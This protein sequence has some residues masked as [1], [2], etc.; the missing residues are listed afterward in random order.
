MTQIKTNQSKQQKVSLRRLDDFVKPEELLFIVYVLGKELESFCF[1]T[2]QSIRRIHGLRFEVKGEQLFCGETLLSN[3]I[4]HVSGLDFLVVLSHGSDTRFLY[5]GTNDLLLS[6]DEKADI[7]LPSDLK[8]TTIGEDLWVKAVS[9]FVYF[10]TKKIVGERQ[11]CPFEVG[12]TLLTADFLLEKRP[13]QWRMTIFSDQVIF[14]LGQFVLQEENPEF[15]QDFPEYRR[16]PRLNLEVP[17]DKFRLQNIEKET[18]A[19]R[20]SLLR[21]IL[22]PVGMLAVTVLISFLSGRNALMMMGMGV[23]SLMTASFTVSQYFRDKKTNKERNV[24]RLESYERYLFGAVSELVKKYDEETEVLRFKQPS[25]QT[26]TG[27]I[28]HFDSRIYERMA[29]QKDFLEVS[30]GTGEMPSQ[31]SLSTDIADRENDEAA[32]RVKKIIQRYHSQKNVPMTMSLLGQ[33]LGLVGAYAHLKTAVDNILLQ[34]A[35]FQSYRDVN[36][37]S[38]VPE[39]EYVPEKD[40]WR[41]LKH[42]KIQDINTRGIIYNAKTRDLILNSFYQ[43]L[44][45]RKQL[46]KEAGKEKPQFTPHYIF[47][48]FD[49]SYLAGHGINEFLAEDMSELGV[50]VIWCKEDQK[51]LP[52]TVTALIEY[53][54]QNAGQIINDKSIYFAKDFVPYEALKDLETPLSRLTSLHHV[55]VE[56]NAIPQSVTFLEMYGV[57]KTCQL[58]IESRWA[59]SDTSKT[60]AVPLGLRGKEDVV[61]LNLHE[62]AH[63]PHGLIAGTTGSGKSEILQSYILSL[64]VNFAPEDVGF[65]PIDFK[66]GGMANLFKDLPHLLG[67]I[68]NLDGAGTERALA[69]IRA[70]LQ[71]RQRLFGQYGV[72]KI[73]SYTKLYKLGKTETDPEEKKKYPNQPL[74]HLFLISDEFAELKTNQPEFMDELVSTARIGRSLGVHLILATQKPS[75]VVN[76]QIWSNSRFKIALKV[77]DAQ[78]SSEILKTPDA[79]SITE[80][81]RAYLQVGNNEIYELFQSAWS[82]A[83]YEPDKMMHHNVDERTYSIN[84]FGQAILTTR[85]LSKDEQVQE[86]LQEKETELDAVVAEIARTAE[87]N[88]VILP[89]KPWLPAL[90]APLPAPEIKRSETRNLKIALGR[91]DIPS[92]QAQKDYIYDIE[93]ASHTAIFSSPGGGKSTTLQT[94]VMS[95]SQQN[96][97][98]QVQFN[99][100]DF[101]TNGLLP[102]K[103]LPNAADIVSLEEKEKLEKMLERIVQAIKGR[104]ELF[105]A[106]D[107]VSLKQYQAKTGETLPVIINLFDGYDNVREH[108]SLDSIETALNMILREGAGLGIYAIATGNRAAA[109][110]GKTLSNIKTRIALYLPD[111]QEATEILGQKGVETPEIAGRGQLVVDGR[112]TELQVYT[113]TDPTDGLAYVSWF[114]VK[115]EELAAEYH[116]VLPEP[117]PMVAR[118]LSFE[119]LPADLQLEQNLERHQLFLGLSQATTIPNAWDLTAEAALIASMDTE[120]QINVFFQLILK[121]LPKN[122]D[123]IET[124]LID[125]NGDFP[126]YKEYFHHYIDEDFSALKTQ[127]LAETGQSEGKRKLYYFVDIESA[128]SEMNFTEAEMKQI[129]KRGS[130]PDNFI[131]QAYNNFIS[132]SFD[133]VMKLLRS[134]VNIG[135]FGVRPGEQKLVPLVKLVTGENYLQ[136]NELY[137]FQGRKFDKLRLPMETD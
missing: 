87:I 120:E 15:P 105:K 83:E 125:S 109:F 103:D 65:L 52:E 135:L 25:P 19:T 24:E 48:I 35:F 29:N 124:I 85:D 67:S 119:A 37:I 98:A 23:M 107:V 110:F 75:G 4:H 101:G 78:D 2:D 73:N 43:I 104:T 81:G 36:F 132:N 12:D 47:T 126:A 38:L 131:F 49:D 45:R 18:K 86:V 26:L 33:T 96:T 40:P 59:K 10:N 128:F 6:N 63:G 62:R 114:K 1:W 54:N 27:M 50:T 8:V 53:K 17:E 136:E 28:Q 129:L 21:A 69:S 71:K 57:E 9:D 16:S 117:I 61:E 121:Q 99:L 20:G 64:A 127:I 5:W 89:E 79:A 44:N 66:G 93:E 39:K 133:N 91:L 60:L 56:K 11:I 34:V 46:F 90:D 112:S 82:G 134:R 111:K 58:R 113:C 72:N 51:L 41:L 137:V 55:E 76:D 100:L 123:K 3:G 94:I 80:P 32:E 108:A 68:T 130:H 102:L 92:R 42:Y 84:E 106:N 97:P 88:G 116:G 14:H 74:P 122:N 13:L 7:Q 95:L 70:E 118:Q 31:L 30:L 115:A 22:P 77:A